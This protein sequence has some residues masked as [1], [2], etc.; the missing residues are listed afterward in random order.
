MHGTVLHR[1]VGV[2][3]ATLPVTPAQFQ[4]PPLERSARAHRAPSQEVRPALGQAPAPLLVGILALCKSP[5]L[6]EHS[7][8]H[9]PGR[10]A[11]FYLES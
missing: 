5:N 8:E 2:R 3:V 10:T 9:S 4:A 1:T 6:H 11:Q 7:P